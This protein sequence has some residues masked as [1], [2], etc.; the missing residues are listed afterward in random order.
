MVRFSDTL[1]NFYVYIVVVQWLSH[2][3]L[4][5]TPWTAALQTSLSFIISRS[6]L[7]VMSIESVMLTNHLILCLYFSFCLHF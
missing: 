5:A 7:S 6:L 2:V 4:F 1:Y 3:Q